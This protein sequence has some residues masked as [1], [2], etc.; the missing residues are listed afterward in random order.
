[1]TDFYLMCEILKNRRLIRKIVPTEKQI[2]IMEF[3]KIKGEI[4][5]VELADKF[6]ISIAN[7]GGQL[8]KLHKNGWLL[9]RN[10]GDPSG[11]NLFSYKNAYIVD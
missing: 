9:R 2:K 4:T 1:M 6:K 8:N 10:I 11:G 7:A 3:I 5:S